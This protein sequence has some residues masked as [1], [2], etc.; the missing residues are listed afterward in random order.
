MKKSVPR[1]IKES[2]SEE[3]IIVDLNSYIEAALEQKGIS[4]A[5]ILGRDDL[6]VDPRSPYK[7]QIPKCWGYGRSASCP[8]HTIK[9]EETL[10]LIDHY[11]HAIFIKTDL[12]PDVVTGIEMAKALMTGEVDPEKKCVEIARSTIN[13]FKAVTKIESMAFY[14]G[15]YFSMGFAAGTC[16][17]TLCWKHENCAVL[18][19][20]K[21]R[22]PYLSRPAMEAAGFDVFKMAARVGWDIYPLGASCLPE[23]ITEGHIMGLVLVT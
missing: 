7:C 17:V 5:V 2:K 22:H 8:P 15:Y 12:T 11:N 10:K 21:C 20:E 1:K 23:D 6:F 9:A 13:I 3:Q 16:R 19:G 14:D 18:N 4:G